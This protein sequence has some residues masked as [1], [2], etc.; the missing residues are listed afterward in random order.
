M[1]TLPYSRIAKIVTVMML[2]ALAANPAFAQPCPDP[3]F[4]VQAIAVGL[5][6][7][8]FVAGDLDGDGDLDLAV[9]N[10][11]NSNHF[12]CGDI[13]VL[14]NNGDGTYATEIRYTVGDSP[15]GIAM[16]DLDGDGDLDLVVVNSNGIVD[17]PFPCYDESIEGFISVLINNGDGTF[18]P[19]VR[20]EAGDQTS[21]VALGDL[22][23]D[24]DLDAVTPNYRENIGVLLNNGDGTFSSPV[25][26]VAG[27]ANSE[28][29][30]IALGDLDQD[31]DL[32]LVTGERTTGVGVL[33]NNGDATFGAATSYATNSGTHS[34][35]IADLDSDGDLDIA[36]GGGLQ[37][38]LMF[39]N[40]DGTF[41][42]EILYETG[43][44]GSASLGD[45][46]GDGDLD[47]ASAHQS[48]G[49]TSVML[50][51]GDG[52][53]ASEVRYATPSSGPVATLLRDLDDDGNL[54][55]AVL[56]Y[57]GNA[58]NILYNN[59]NGAF[60]TLVRYPTGYVP[61]GAAI[62]DL[63]GD[64]DL[65]MAAN[66]SQGVSVLLNNGDASFA[67]ETPYGIEGTPSSFPIRVAFGDL[68]G[69]G[70]LD[71]TVADGAHT[72]MFVFLNSGDGTFTAP[73][74]YTTVT[75]M[76]EVEL[77]DLDGDGDLDMAVPTGSYGGDI[78]LLFNNGNGSFS[79]PVS[80][81]VGDDPY[82]V[83]LGDLDSDGDLDMTVSTGG[84][85]FIYVLFNNGNG[86]FGTAATYPFS[87]TTNMSLGDFDA[88]GDLDMAA[89]NHSLNGISVFL[90]N[91]NGAFASEILYPAGNGISRVS[92][93]DLDLDGDLDIAVGAYIGDS[94][95]SGT[96]VLFNFGNG[97]FS[98]PITFATGFERNSISL[99]DLDN[100]GD[101]DLVGADRTYIDGNGFVDVL[102]NQC[103]ELVVCDADL[104]ADGA[105]DIFDV[106]AYIDAYNAGEPVAEFDGVPGLDIFDV[107][108]FLD[109]FNAG[110]P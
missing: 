62:G 48:A 51:N 27:A 41:E 8:D 50:N 17:F 83:S 77:G 49:D 70:D 12:A 46:D 26:Y 61:E 39:N 30:D 1:P 94:F 57:W 42:P 32:D 74:L 13:S 102:L 76:T 92:L 105:L 29:K 6:P 90:N 109:A 7:R 52:T 78:A 58:V 44:G 23:G 14:F 71:M 67:P 81:E 91:G 40:G 47:V 24:G 75:Q 88:D 97:T 54:D 35:S 33:F 95:E 68:D 100:D 82:R 45:I 4:P 34:I 79:A 87:S 89:V 36:K 16:G 65:D 72:D 2:P 28:F 69:D 31:G 98:E 73:N 56:C 66:Y 18:A 5:D 60:D 19:Y 21:L 25:A 22:D 84:S 37:I 93:G 53:F 106:F 20:Y 11:Y 64:G 96:N 85:N 15:R 63:D 38:S 103:I 86:V 43:T 80:H 108:A 9:V 101:L 10:T 99:G 59:G 3:L 107:F 110:C 55:L 104:N